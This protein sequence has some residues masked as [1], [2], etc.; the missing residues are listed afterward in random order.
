MKIKISAIIFLSLI[1]IMTNGQ[2]DSNTFGFVAYWSQGD[3]YDFK[4]TKIQK[5]W[6]EGVLIKNDSTQVI[7]N[8]KVQQETDSLYQINWSFK[9]NLANTYD[10]PDTV[11]ESLSDYAIMEVLYN[12]TEL[13]EYIGITNWEEIRD[14][15]QGL[16][17]IVFTAVAEQQGEDPDEMLKMA[18]PVLAIYNSKQGVEQLVFPELQSFHFPFGLEYSHD[19][20]FEYEDL[21]PNMFGGDPIRGD[22]VLFVDSVDFEN[23]Y[24]ILK[25]QM[26]LNPEDTKAVILQ[27]FKQ[28]GISDKEF[29]KFSKTAVFEINTDNTYE[30]YYNPGVPIKIETLRETMI[31]IDKEKGKRVDK[32]VIELLP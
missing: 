6:K 4:V 17:K 23:Q 31:D 14:I 28:M 25:Q 18:E 8:F 13:G 15:M 24:C 1:C 10:L 11:L 5:R 7:T 19:S 27:L 32:L 30:Y 3:S 16:F 20:Y 2:A 9:N 21:I 29:K 26:K 22:A 12:T